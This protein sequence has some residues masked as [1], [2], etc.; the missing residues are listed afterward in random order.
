[1]DLEEI[2]LLGASR[3][4]SLQVQANKGSYAKIDEV[5]KP[6]GWLGPEQE[7]QAL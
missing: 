2:C 7:R 4:A 3:K 5:L 6:L 1:L